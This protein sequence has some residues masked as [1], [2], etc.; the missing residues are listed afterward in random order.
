MPFDLLLARFVAKEH[1]LVCYGL[2]RMNIRH[3]RSP[4]SVRRFPVRSRNLPTPP[5]PNRAELSVLVAWLLGSAQ[6]ASCHSLRPW[7]ENIE[8]PDFYSMSTVLYNTVLYSTISLKKGLCTFHLHLSITL[9]KDS[10]LSAMLPAIMWGAQ[11][12]T[13]SRSAHDRKISLSV[14]CGISQRVCKVASLS[15]TG[16]IQQE[17]VRYLICTKHCRPMTREECGWWQSGSAPFLKE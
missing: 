13:T 7:T 12:C 5:E 1:C 10:R 11:S 14:A 2:R 16:H 15:S 17:I 9:A 4:V 6:E 8:N 3:T